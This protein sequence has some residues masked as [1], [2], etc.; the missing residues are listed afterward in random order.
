MLQY[1]CTLYQKKNKYVAD[2]IVYLVGGNSLV[3]LSCF[4]EILHYFTY[5]EIKKMDNWITKSFFD[6]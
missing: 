2:D 1:N 6:R 3:Y 5:N 4:T